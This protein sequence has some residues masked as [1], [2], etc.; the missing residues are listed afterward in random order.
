MS[1]TNIVLL[2]I[3]PFMSV[4][5]CFMHLNVPMLGAYVVTYRYNYIFFLDCS[6]DHYVLSFF[7][8]CNSLYFKVYFVWY[9][10]CYLTFF[11]FF[12]PL[13][14][15]LCISLNLKWVSCRQH[16]FGSCFYIHSATL[17]VLIGAFS[18]FTFKGII[19]MYVIIAILLIILEL[20]CGPLYFPFF[21]CSL[22]MWW[23][24]LELYLD[25]FFFLCVY[26]L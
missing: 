14:F 24:S 2:L 21:F 15:S 1:P 19:D 25:S 12:H 3:S 4:N 20:F 11:F 22:V 26:M 13:T 5:I 9:N 17:C 8:S 7:V 16:L 18:T 6:L 23:L 10:F